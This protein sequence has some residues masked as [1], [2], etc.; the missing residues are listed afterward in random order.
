M[1]ARSSETTSGMPPTRVATT[2]RPQESDS[3]TTFGVP[4]IQLGST[5]RSLAAIHWSISA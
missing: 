5:T 4:S 2:G 1:P 3:R